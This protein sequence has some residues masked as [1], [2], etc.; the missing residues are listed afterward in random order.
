M[1]STL[2]VLIVY[3][4]N[5]K[6]NLESNPRFANR[7]WFGSE[8]SVHSTDWRTDFQIQLVLE[9]VAFE[10]SEAWRLGSLIQFRGHLP[11]QSSGWMLNCI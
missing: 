2:E 9:I 10:S 7:S 1:P 5:E 8:R 11:I 6:V 4:V 3:S